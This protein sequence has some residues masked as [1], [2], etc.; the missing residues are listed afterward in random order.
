MLT[1]EVSQQKMIHLKSKELFFLAGVLGSERLLGVEDPFQGYLA[2]ELTREWEEVKTSLLE[3]GYLRQ[4]EEGASWQF[5]RP[6]SQE[7]LL[8]D[9]P[10]EHV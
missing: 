7:S 8:P 4:V 2:E 10:E 9:C 1:F 5:R 3:K 6:S